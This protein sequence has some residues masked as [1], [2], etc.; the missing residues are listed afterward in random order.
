MQLDEGPHWGAG[1]THLM[2]LKWMMGNQ[3]REA[4]KVIRWSMF[5]M[6]FTAVTHHTKGQVTLKKDIKK[7]KVTANNKHTIHL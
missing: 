6:S 4:V 5:F 7:K 2:G 1:L 3:G